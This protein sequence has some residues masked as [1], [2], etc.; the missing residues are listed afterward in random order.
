M[1]LCRRC[2][3][4]PSCAADDRRRVGRRQALLGHGCMH[5]VLRRS[6]QTVVFHVIG[7]ICSSLLLVM[8]L[9]WNFTVQVGDIL[10]ARGITD[11]LGGSHSRLP[12]SGSRA[13]CQTP[14][15]PWGFT[16]IYKRMFLRINMRDSIVNQ[17]AEAGS[18]TSVQL[19]RWGPLGGTYLIP[20]TGWVGVGECVVRLRDRELS[21][22]WRQNNASRAGSTYI[23]PGVQHTASATICSGSK[24]GRQ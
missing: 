16:S 2:R 7:I 15:L 8:L 1:T 6:Q 24:K 11:A 9:L 23:T 17:L 21:T 14:R 22:S 19:R 12:A 20:D 3:G 13:R 10:P 4:Y 18:P 5:V